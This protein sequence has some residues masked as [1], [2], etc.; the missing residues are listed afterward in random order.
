ME[1]INEEIFIEATKRTAKNRDSLQIFDDIA[2]QV[3]SISESD[4]LKK[5]WEGYRKSYFMLKK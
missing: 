3:K 4:N 2:E 1:K 5:H